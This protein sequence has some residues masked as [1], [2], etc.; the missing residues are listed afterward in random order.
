MLNELLRTG[1]MISRG[2]TF[3]VGDSRHVLQLLRG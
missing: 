2:H 3:G 1:G